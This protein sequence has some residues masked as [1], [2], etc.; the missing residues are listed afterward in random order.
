MIFVSLHVF[1]VMEA[2]GCVQSHATHSMQESSQPC[3]TGQLHLA[4]QKRK[5]RDGPLTRRTVFKQ[6]EPLGMNGWHRKE[7]ILT[8]EVAHCIIFCII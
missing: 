3:F 6:S 2:C 5:D 7:G 1:T 8:S 4:V